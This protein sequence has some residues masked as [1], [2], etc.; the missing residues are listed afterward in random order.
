MEYKELGKSGEKIPVIGMGT[1]KMGFNPKQEVEALRYG[2]EK[3]IRFIDTAES[4]GSEEIVGRAIQN[5][6]GVFIATKVSPEHFHHQDVIDACNGSLKRLGI[7]RID[8]YQVHWPNPS[9]PI[10]ETMG[11]METLIDEGKIR[12]IGVSNFSVDQLTRAQRAL[13]KNEIVSNQVEYSLFVRNIE[14]DLLP[15]CDREKITVIA[16]SPFARGTFFEGRPQGLSDALNE[17]A[18]KYGKTV[19]QVALNWLIAKKSVVAIP[20]ASNKKHMDENAG[21]AGWKLAREDQERISSAS[22]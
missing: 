15:F 9:I 10:E 19:A 14:R 22:Q 6:K 2:F 17:A 18:S 11:A 20:K 12:Y 7:K 5:E 16:Y 8:L 4:Y 3:G 13:K 1:W 21:A